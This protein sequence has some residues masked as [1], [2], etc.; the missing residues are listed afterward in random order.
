[1]TARVEFGIDFEAPA[2]LPILGI[3]RQEATPVAV[4]TIHI[5]PDED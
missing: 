5:Y 2:R 1:M 4:Y 3:D